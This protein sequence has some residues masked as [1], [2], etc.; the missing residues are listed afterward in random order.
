MIFFTPNLHFAVD[1][2]KAHIWLA[3]GR[4][5]H[6]PIPALLE[7]RLRGA[8]TSRHSEITGEPIVEL[9]GDDPLLDT[10]KNTKN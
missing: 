1:G 10:M 4:R 9:S 6:T 3:G 7:Q 5:G 2:Y 8:W